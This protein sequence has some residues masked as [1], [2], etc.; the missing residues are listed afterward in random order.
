MPGKVC[1]RAT[2]DM[3]I[4]SNILFIISYNVYFSYPAVNIIYLY[5]KKELLKAWR[6]SNI[7]KHVVAIRN[8]H[9]NPTQNG[10]V[11]QMTNPVQ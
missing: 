1:D 4:P 9:V 5:N 6:S 2:V 8:T 10:T 7:A 11:L 3:L